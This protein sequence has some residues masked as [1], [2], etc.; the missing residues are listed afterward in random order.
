MGT[1]TWSG[2]NCAEQI[3]TADWDIFYACIQSPFSFEIIPRLLYV[4]ARDGWLRGNI[5]SLISNF[6]LNIPNTLSLSAILRNIASKFA[7]VIAKVGCYAGKLFR[8]CWDFL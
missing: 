6:F 4:T 7:Y 2:I 5:L 8:I 3:S 1:L